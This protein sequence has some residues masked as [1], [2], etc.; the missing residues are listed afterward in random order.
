M[1]IQKICT[2][3][4]FY[5]VTINLSKVVAWV[6]VL[7]F[8]GVQLIDIVLVLLYWNQQS[9]RKIFLPRY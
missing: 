5:F 9:R 8:I 7:F 2:T 3:T 4:L 1:R 6:P